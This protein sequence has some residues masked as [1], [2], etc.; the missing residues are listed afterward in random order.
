M[1]C[2]TA[3]SCFTSGCLLISPFLPF[4]LEG[5]AGAGFCPTGFFLA[6]FIVTTLVLP[7][8]PTSASV[9]R[10]HSYALIGL[11]RVPASSSPALSSHP[12]APRLRL[13]SSLRRIGHAIQEVVVI[14]EPQGLDGE[15]RGYI[16]VVDR[17]QVIA[18]RGFAARR[19]V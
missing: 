2:A 1:P 18:I 19:Q 17:E 10:P 6:F 4:P 14:N 9:Q 11:S 5:S 8:F 13:R 3:A 16:G 12:R 15:R 7:I